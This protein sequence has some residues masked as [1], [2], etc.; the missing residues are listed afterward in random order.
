MILI[1]NGCAEV[2]YSATQPSASPPLSI[3][4]L[5][6]YILALCRSFYT[7]LC[8]FQ[9]NVWYASIQVKTLRRGGSTWYNF[10]ESLALSR[11]LVTLLPSRT[12]SG[13]CVL[14]SKSRV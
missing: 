13:Q 9:R 8:G 3:F 4:P 2:I 6:I 5:F 1:R 12:V 10:Y 11:D 7:G 14:I